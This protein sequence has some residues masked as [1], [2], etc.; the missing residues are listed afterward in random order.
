MRVCCGLGPH[1]ELAQRRDLYGSP[2]VVGHWEE[3][4]IAASDETVQFGVV[5]GM[6]MRQAE[7]LCP[8]AA[9]LTPDPLAACRLRELIASALYDVAPVVEVS[10]EGVAWLEL[11]G[12]PSPSASIR[13][14]R[15]CL[16]TA[17]GVEPRLGLAPGPFTAR[18][19]RCVETWP[20]SS[21]CVVRAPSR[22][23]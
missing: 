3:Q 21:A 10:G 17:V 12:V 8:Q 4:V 18:L 15:R 6:P 9:F 22:C 7:H 5:P 14:A 20:W 16:R 19:D 23:A 11:S 13:E 2:V 1:L